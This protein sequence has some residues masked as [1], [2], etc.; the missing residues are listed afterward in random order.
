[1]TKNSVKELVH[2]DFVLPE[3]H[4]PP[5][6]M[7]YEFSPFKNNVIAIWILYKRRFHYNSGDQ[8]RCI[9]G[10]YNTKTKSYHAPINSSKQ[11][12][13]VELKNT[14]PYSAMPLN[15]NPLMQCLM[16]LN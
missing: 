8:V 12:D 11:G 2:K 4:S 9:W 3:F 5:E 16:S 6:G 10:F 13:Q 1:M 7:Y 15:L 14:T